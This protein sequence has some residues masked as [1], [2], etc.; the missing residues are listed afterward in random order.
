MNAETEL[1]VLIN[2]KIFRADDIVHVDL[3]PDDKYV[4]SGDMVTGRIE[5]VKTHSIT[6]DTSTLYKNSL[7]NIGLNSIHDINLKAD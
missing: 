4:T 3:V 6:L 7:M 1:M 5:Y 2:D